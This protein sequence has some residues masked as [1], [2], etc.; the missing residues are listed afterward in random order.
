MG[1]WTKIISAIPIVFAGYEVGKTVNDKDN[2]ESQTVQ[3]KNSEENNYVNLF[4][5]IGLGLTVIVIIM[6]Y[7][8]KKLINTLT[9]PRAQQ[10]I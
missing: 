10:R 9:T 8:F 1:W 6:F 4:L 3:I 7:F 2:K 5:E